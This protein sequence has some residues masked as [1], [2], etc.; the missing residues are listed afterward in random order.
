M[1]CKYEPASFRTP[2]GMYVPDFQTRLAWIEIK[3][4]D[5]PKTE[6]EA[7]KIMALAAGQKKPVFVFCGRPEIQ[8][9]SDGLD[10]C[11]FGIY[12]ATP[13]RWN[14]T[15]SGRRLEILQTIAGVPLLEG[16]ERKYLIARLYR[17]LEELRTQHA[18]P[19]RALIEQGWQAI[20]GWAKLE[21]QQ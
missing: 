12:R 7:R 20:L 9:F 15:I 17:N 5:G 1:E 21:Q 10:L 13:A 3:S 19:I 16:L 4:V 14:N 18:Q 11:N 2:A 8:G 6:Q